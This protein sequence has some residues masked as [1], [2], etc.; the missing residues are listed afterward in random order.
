[1]TYILL[2]ALLFLLAYSKIQDIMIRS[3]K[4]CINTLTDALCESNQ[5]LELQRITNSYQKA[6]IGQ[7]NI[8]ITTMCQAVDEHCEKVQ[9]ADIQAWAKK[10]QEE[11]KH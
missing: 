6:A 10:I 4:D 2:L 3:Q 5:E 1:M 11:S 7:L 8:I 9:S